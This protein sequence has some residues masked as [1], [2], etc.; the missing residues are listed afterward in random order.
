MLYL[1][2]KKILIIEVSLIN[3]DLSIISMVIIDRICK[4]TF[5]EQF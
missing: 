4:C 3:E 2:H 5:P 1:F